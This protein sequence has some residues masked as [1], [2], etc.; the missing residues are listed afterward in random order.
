[1]P[2]SSCY[3]DGD[4]ARYSKQKPVEFIPNKKVVWLV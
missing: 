4:N 2:N 1:M 3:G